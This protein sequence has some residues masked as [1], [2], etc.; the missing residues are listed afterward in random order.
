MILTSTYFDWSNPPVWRTFGQTD[1]RT[2][3]SI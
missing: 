1:G 3:D 2:D